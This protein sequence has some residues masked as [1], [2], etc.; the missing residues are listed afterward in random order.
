MPVNRLRN[1]DEIVTQSGTVIDL[2]NIQA[3][4]GGAGSVSN[5]DLGISMSE[6]SSAI[7][8]DLNAD[9]ALYADGHSKSVTSAFAFGGLN[10]TSNGYRSDYEEVSFA[11]LSASATQHTGLQTAKQ[12]ARAE[13]V[14]QTIYHVCGHV[15][16]VGVIGGIE[17]IALPTR[18]NSTLT[19]TLTATHAGLGFS[20]G[21]KIVS[22]GGNTSG[23]TY[24]THMNSFNSA[25]ESVD[26]SYGTLTAGNGGAGSVSNGTEGMI[27]GG[28]AQGTSNPIKTV[29]KFSFASGGTN[30]G[31]GEIAEASK[32]VEGSSN[33]TTGF[34]AGAYKSAISQDIFAHSFSDNSTQAKFGQMVWSQYGGGE[35]SNGEIGVRMAGND[36]TPTRNSDAF[37]MT[38]GSSYTIGSVADHRYHTAGASG[39]S[40]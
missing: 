7:Y 17:K 25:D 3:S 39:S 35:S 26:N 9:T 14:G 23:S 11:D 30:T 1:I 18:A 38:D 24:H 6:T 12:S 22:A 10:A 15:D 31:F 36:S 21:S 32:W 19:P 40:T 29:S 16:G 34:I 5:T 4:G 33:D 27:I 28:F 2:D 37:N 13:S 20:N 8:Y